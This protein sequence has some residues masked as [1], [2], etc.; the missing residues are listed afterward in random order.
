MRVREISIKDFNEWLKLR[1]AL[2][3]YHTFKELEK[4]GRH[5]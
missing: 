1:H 3:P 4:N 2:W 5:I